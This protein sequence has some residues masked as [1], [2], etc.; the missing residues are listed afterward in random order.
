MAGRADLSLAAYAAAIS[1]K[2]RK[3]RIASRV[4][5]AAE[6]ARVAKVAQKTEAEPFVSPA[7]KAPF[8]IAIGGVSKSKRVR[9][10]KAM[11]CATAHK[12][13]H[14]RK[15]MFDEFLSETSRLI[16]LR[17]KM[18]EAIR[19]MYVDPNDLSLLGNT[20]TREFFSAIFGISNC[21]QG[22]ESSGVVFGYA[23][24]AC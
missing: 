24:P 20:E 21:L 5:A 22:S 17:N 2:E 7:S 3:D 14:I 9:R 19:P 10:R 1:P 15:G 12:T 8:C 16:D 11:N 4:E 23:A 18:Y 13:N 6:A